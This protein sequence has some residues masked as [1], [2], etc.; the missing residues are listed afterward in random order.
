MSF[1]GGGWEMTQS[2]SGKRISADPAKSQQPD[3]N[4]EVTRGVNT[5]SR[6]AF[7]W[8]ALVIGGL[9]GDD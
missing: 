8:H 7:A 3:G 4:A 2:L 9:I 6:L 1:A 5:F